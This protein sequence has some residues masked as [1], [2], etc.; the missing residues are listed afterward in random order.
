MAKAGFTLA[1]A[2]SFSQRLIGHIL[3][4]DKFEAGMKITSSN[5]V[6]LVHLRQLLR[7]I[8]GDCCADL[9]SCDYTC[10]RHVIDV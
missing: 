9:I 5:L 6:S 1:D 2:E 4:V 7:S 3:V 10:K 8:N